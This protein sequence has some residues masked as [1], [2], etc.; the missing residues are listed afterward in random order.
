MLRRSLALSRQ[1]FRVVDPVRI[2]SKVLAKNREINPV[3]ARGKV[4]DDDHPRAAQL[5]QNVE[6]ICNLKPD[7]VKRIKNIVNGEKRGGKY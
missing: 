3:Y 5:S 7:F 2:V 6:Q 4:I 1:K